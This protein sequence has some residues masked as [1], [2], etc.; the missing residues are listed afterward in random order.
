MMTES[1]YAQP[2]N[3]VISTKSPSGGYPKKIIK[4]KKKNL[5]KRAVVTPSPNF[6]NTKNLFYVPVHLLI[7]P[8]L[9]I[10]A[11]QK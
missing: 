6:L 8:T 10:V 9:D 5:N 2:L 11:Q 1:P 4:T 7:M 3:F